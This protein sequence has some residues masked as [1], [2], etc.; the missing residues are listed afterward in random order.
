MVVYPPP[1]YV[2]WPASLCAY[3]NVAPSWQRHRVL[4]QRPVAETAAGMTGGLVTD[5]QAYAVLPVVSPAVTLLL[6]VLSMLPPLWTLW[7]KPTMPTFVRAVYMCGF[8]TFLFGWHVHEKAIMLVTIPLCLIATDSKQNARRL[9]SLSA[10]GYAALFPLLYEPQETV[11]KCALLVA[12]CAGGYAGLTACLG[13]GDLG[14]GWFESAYLAGLVLLK[15]FVSVVHPAVIAPRLPFLPLM[16]TSV[17]CGAGLV[18][19]WLADLADDFMGTNSNGG[20]GRDSISS[21]SNSRNKAGSSRTS[22]SGQN[23]KPSKAKDA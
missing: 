19:L 16:A 15:L 8:G 1:L 20:S 5:Q 2:G 12:Y 22:N 17:Y 7:F 21:N 9:L 23:R 3:A 11:L 6:S 14:Y 10:A 18:G 4:I 13:G